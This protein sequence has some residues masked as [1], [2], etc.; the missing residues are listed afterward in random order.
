MAWRRSCASASISIPFS[1]H[2]FLFRNRRGDRLKILAWDHGGFW[3]LYERLRD[4]PARLALGTRA[5]SMRLANELW[6]R[7]SVVTK[8]AD[9]ADTP[10]PAGRNRHLIAIAWDGLRAVRIAVDF[11]NWD[12][13]THGHAWRLGVTVRAEQS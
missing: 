11:F 10:G 3:V 8:S 6:G 4:I 12:L 13:E 2:V 5:P 9:A 1:G 7:I